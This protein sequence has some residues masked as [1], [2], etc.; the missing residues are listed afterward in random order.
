MASAGAPA[1]PQAGRPASNFDVIVVGAG[2]MGSCTAHA[3][4]SRG[5]R[6]LLLE[7]FDLLHPLGSSHGDSRIIR[8]AYAQPRYL[9]MVRLAR[10]LW[11]AAE[12]EA[13]YRVLTPT[14]HLSMGPRSSASL[15][16]AI[17]NIGAEE[18]DEDDLHRRWGGAFALTVPGPVDGWVT[19]LSDHGGVLS[20]TKAVAMFQSLAV[21]KGAV[22]RDN[23]EVVGIDRAPEPDGGGVVVRAAG[24]E[25]FRGARCVVTV[26]AWAAKLLGSWGVDL[27]IRPLHTLHLYWRVKPG[28]EQTVSASAGFPTFSSY[29]D[30][31][32]YGAPSLE[33]PGLIK[34]SCDGGPPCD[35][36]A[37]DWLAGDA[38][39]THRVARWIQEAM[40]DHVDAAG[41]PVVRQ[42]CIC[43]MTPDA[44]FVMD[45]L[46]GGRDVVVGAGFSGHGFK[47]GP[48]VGKILAEMAI[49][50]GSETA[51]EAGLD[52]GFFRIGR[53]DGNPM[54]N[55]KKD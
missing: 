14:P 45:F 41:G 44:D 2:I 4:A 25:A 18:V 49:D 24:G 38:E 26:G 36:D 22:V 33:L 54:G 40:P 28:Q 3:A 20:A 29:G 55:A 7:R 11:A 21:A 12:A 31:P 9:R 30:P 52:L 34:I 13:G 32:V 27:P 47:M 1:V 51:E 5:A 10:R 46:G 15:A 48:A 53:F 37:R 17:A 39:V 19:A 35:P 42:S 16:A 43:S 50:G 6:V 8:D 23:T